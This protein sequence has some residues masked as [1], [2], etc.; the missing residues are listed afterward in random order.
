MYLE[1]QIQQVRHKW[2]IWRLRRNMQGT[3]DIFRGKSLTNKIP[4]MYLEVKL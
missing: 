4:L 2:G 3:T 1:V